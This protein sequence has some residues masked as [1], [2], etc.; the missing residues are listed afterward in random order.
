MRTV[1][2]MS[3]VVLCALLWAARAQHIRATDG[4]TWCDSG[5]GYQELGITQCPQGGGDCDDACA[6][7]GEDFNYQ[8]DSDCSDPYF[9]DN[10][11]SGGF[12]WYAEDLE[13]KCVQ[14]I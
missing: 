9:D 10:F 14:E 4:D 13:C 12:G 1:R 2:N 6:A 3:F 5:W 11:Y 7:C 8:G